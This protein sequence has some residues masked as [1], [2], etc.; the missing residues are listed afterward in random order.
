[1]LLVMSQRLPTL[2]DIP[3]CADLRAVGITPPAWLEDLETAF[4]PSA[5][6]RLLRAVAGR[7]I[8]IPT[9]DVSGSALDR[10]VG[11]RVARWMQREMGFGRLRVPLAG[12]AVGARR[13]VVIRAWLAAGRS[14]EETAAAAQCSARYVSTMKARL[15][16]QGFLS[17]GKSA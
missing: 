16:A 17:E 3:S 10:A 4:G 5:P 2:E 1:M 8:D 13:R 6:R 9:R 7:Q 11:P 14:L 12:A 15:R